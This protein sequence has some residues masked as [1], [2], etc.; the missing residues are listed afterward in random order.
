MIG[1]QNFRLALR[2]VAHARRQRA[3]GAATVAAILLLALHGLPVLDQLAAAAAWTLV[4]NAFFDHA[5]T[6][7][8]VS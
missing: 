6:I 2:R 1:S 8:S 5:L 3:V 4:A 7:P